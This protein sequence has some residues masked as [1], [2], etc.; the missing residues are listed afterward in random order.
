MKRKQQQQQKTLFFILLGVF[1]LSII[2]MNRFVK[3]S[4]KQSG[5]VNAVVAVGEEGEA[6][7]PVRRPLGKYPLIEDDPAQYNIKVQGRTDVPLTEQQWEYQMRQGLANVGQGAESP[8]TGIAK[9]PEE[10]AD[11][12]EEITSQIKEYETITATNP[13]DRKAQEHL[14]TL[15][16]LKA[17]LTILKDKVTSTNST[18]PPDDFLSG[19]PRD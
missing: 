16:M 10:V 8:L 17:T 6:E 4:L 15:Y 13:G 3:T 18:E 1:L 19:S 12:M 11:Q 5:E 14:Q 2:L 9:T 7:V